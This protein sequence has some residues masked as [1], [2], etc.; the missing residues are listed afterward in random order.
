MEAKH[1]FNSRLKDFRA[2]AKKIEQEHLFTDEFKDWDPHIQLLLSGL[3]YAE[4]NLKEYCEQ[5]ITEFLQQLALHYVPGEVIARPGVYCAELRAAVPGNTDWKPLAMLAFGCVNEDTSNNANVIGYLGKR[6]AYVVPG[7]QLTCSLQEDD[8]ERSKIIFRLSCP[9]RPDIDFP[10]LLFQYEEDYGFYDLLWSLRGQKVSGVTIS[11]APQY[12]EYQWTGTPWYQESYRHL[13]PYPR[14]L[15]RFFEL[16]GISHEHWEKGEEG[17]Y[18]TEISFQIPKPPHQVMISLPH[19]IE[20]TTNV[21]LVYAYHQ[22]R[23]MWLEGH[24]KKSLLQGTEGQAKYLSWIRVEGRT[25]RLFPP[26]SLFLNQI[27]KNSSGENW[28]WIPP[29]RKDDVAAE[30]RGADAEIWMDC[31][32]IQELDKGQTRPEKLRTIQY[33]WDNPSERNRQEYS[34]ETTLSQLE[35]LKERQ[36][37]QKIRKNLWDWL[38]RNYCNT[39]H[40]QLFQKHIQNYL[41]QKEIDIQKDQIEIRL[42]GPTAARFMH[43]PGRGLVPVFEVEILLP[44][45]I[46]P[47]QSWYSFR[48]RLIAA[49]TRYS[50]FLQERLPPH[51]RLVISLLHT[52]YQDEQGNGG[53]SCSREKRQCKCSLLLTSP[54]DEI[55]SSGDSGNIR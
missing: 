37:P 26:T 13:E 28:Y 41:S 9:N 30:L 38:S 12:F 18:F 42:H 32:L 52:Y 55:P 36:T 33:P 31:I 7:L 24:S 48:G 43:V 50:Q 5:R 15:D 39:E 40:P 4:E 46:H 11:P 51:L 2:F 35:K 16:Q 47:E 27:V 49:L 44:K 8:A 45:E 6:G 1:K 20:F 3:F 14:G 53:C 34:I 10:P 54:D 23:P 29:D 22:Q 21:F 19:K 17:D 25:E